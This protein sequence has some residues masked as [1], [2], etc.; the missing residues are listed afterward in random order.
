MA[1]HSGSN[2]DGS[3]LEFLKKDP[4]KNID[5]HR[6][7]KPP[8]PDSSHMAHKW[9]VGTTKFTYHKVTNEGKLDRTGME[10]R[11]FPR[12]K[13]DNI[14]FDPPANERSFQKEYDLMVTKPKY[15][16]NVRSGNPWEPFAGELKTINNRSSV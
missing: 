8:P 4:Y 6:D 12:N 13:T 3:Y 5:V 7:S 14:S 15:N 1:A 2:P 11:V 16:I 9:P 10:P